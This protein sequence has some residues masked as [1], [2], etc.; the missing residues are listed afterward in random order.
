LKTIYQNAKFSLKTHHTIP[1]EEVALQNIDFWV[2]IDGQTFLGSASTTENIQYL[3]QKN[4]QTGECA[5][6]TYHWQ[7][8]MII[9]S[10]FTIRCL[11]VA[12]ADIIEDESLVVDQVFYLIPEYYE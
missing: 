12:V 6:G 11:A 5:L 10:E 2:I 7:S 1:H 3:M 9:L 4:K 8:N